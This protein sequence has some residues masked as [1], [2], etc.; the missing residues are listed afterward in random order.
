MKDEVNHEKEEDEEKERKKEREEEEAQTY[1]DLINT[2]DGRCC[3]PVWW[4]SQ[5]S[6]IHGQMGRAVKDQLLVFQKIAA[7]PQH[8]CL[9]SYFSELGVYFLR[10]AGMYYGTS[11]IFTVCLILRPRLIQISW[12]I[13]RM[14]PH[15]PTIHPWLLSRDWQARSMSKSIPIDLHSQSLFYINISFLN[16]SVSGNNSTTEWKKVYTYRYVR[17]QWYKWMCQSGGG[18]PLPCTSN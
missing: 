2:R 3:R 8:A 5:P 15:P 18:C 17:M 13:Q 12:S 11:T 16:C 7:V 9:F 10:G 4:R 6:S 14:I 1:L